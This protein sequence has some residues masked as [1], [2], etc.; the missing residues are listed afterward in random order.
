[1]FKEQV[2]KPPVKIK[3][4]F[5]FTY[6]YGRLL[7]LIFFQE[8][9]DLKFTPLYIVQ[10]STLWDV[11]TGQ[12]KAKLNGHSD[13]V[14]SVCF[15]PDGIRLASGCNDNSICLW[16]VTKIIL[17]NVQTQNNL[18]EFTNSY[19]TILRISKSLVFLSQNTLVLKGKFVNHQGVDLR[20]L[21]ISKGSTFLVNDKEK[22]QKNK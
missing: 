20:Q 7:P 2:S 22:L 5:Q 13:Q 21:L 11:Y 4:I 8:Q 1:M 3:S 10:R 12:Q 16:I 9:L 18:I 17:S 15:S 6:W 14:N 19:M